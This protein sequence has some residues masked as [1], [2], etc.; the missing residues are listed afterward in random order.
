M[1]TGI[2]KKPRN[3][4]RTSAVVDKAEVYDLIPG[5]VVVMDTNHTVLDLNEPAAKTAG[6]TKEECIGA[7]F[8][9]LYLTTR[10]AGPELVLRL[11]Q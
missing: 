5:M 1:T 11:K 7:K 10:V 2:G 9:D 8:W 4:G 6:K 3:G